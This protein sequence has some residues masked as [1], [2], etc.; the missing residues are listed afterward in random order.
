MKERVIENP[1]TRCV[2]LV[3]FCI[4]LLRTC[5]RV[6]P[7]LDDS[8]SC[9]GPMKISS[10]VRLQSD[11]WETMSFLLVAISRSGWCFPM[12]PLSVVLLW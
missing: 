12:G 11:N 8:D 1:R 2:M 5:R 6:P 7:L 10:L 4:F 3:S 9:T